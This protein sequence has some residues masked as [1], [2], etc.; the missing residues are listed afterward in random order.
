[1]MA[2]SVKSVNLSG[3]IQYCNFQKI[4]LKVNP[5]VNGIGVKYSLMVLEEGGYL[6]HVSVLTSLLVNSI[7]YYELKL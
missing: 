5:R 2:A 7:F 4:G 6:H 1:M 3:R